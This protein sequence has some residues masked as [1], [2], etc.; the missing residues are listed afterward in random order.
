MLAPDAISP[1]ITTIAQRDAVICLL[2]RAELA[3]ETGK[4]PVSHESQLRYHIARVCKL[5]GIPTIAE[6]DSSKIEALS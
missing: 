2:T 6:R 1:D 5:F 4:L 3:V